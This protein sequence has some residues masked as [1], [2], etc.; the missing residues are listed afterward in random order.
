M[1]HVQLDYT[2]LS[3][4]VEFIVIMYLFVDYTTF[5]MHYQ[6]IL[7]EHS[8]GPGVE[9]KKEKGYP[10]RYRLVFLK[11]ETVHG[12]WE[13]PALCGPERSGDARAPGELSLAW[14]EAERRHS[15]LRAQDWTRKKK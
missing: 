8:R 3:L 13:T 7:E 15:K 9:S 14:T 11:R 6:P 4:T 2:I 10:F 1:Q 5:T 12:V